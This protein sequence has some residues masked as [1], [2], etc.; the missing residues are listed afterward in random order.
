MSATRMGTFATWQGHGSG[1]WHRP[2]ESRRYADPDLSVR[3]VA[4]HDR[5]RADLAVRADPVSAD[6]DRTWSDE[7]AVPEHRR[8]A[9]AMV[10][11]DVLLNGAVGTDDNLR[12][13][14]YSDRVEE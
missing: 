2:Q 12:T 5:V 10:E 3:H 1:S 14:D 13:D 9:S 11:G 7:D 4:D 6:D 8:A